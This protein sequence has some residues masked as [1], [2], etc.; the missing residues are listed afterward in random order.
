MEKGLFC[1]L[2]AH[3][4]HFNPNIS[5]SSS[6]TCNQNVNHRGYD[7][8]TSITRKLLLLNAY[9]EI[10]K[11]KNAGASTGNVYQSLTFSALS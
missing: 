2:S 6:E 4:Q 10:R 1:N 7:N 3:L 11:I 5:T 8:D 9:Y